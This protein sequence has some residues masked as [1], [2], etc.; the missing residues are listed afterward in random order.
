MFAIERF[1]AGMHDNPET[2]VDRR[3]HMVR[4]EKFS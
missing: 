3:C 1:L 4:G 2:E